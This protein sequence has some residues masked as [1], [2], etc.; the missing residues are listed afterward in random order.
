MT[1]FVETPISDVV[2]GEN[3]EVLDAILQKSAVVKN[4]LYKGGFLAGGF[5]RAILRG[6]SLCQ[7][8]SPS[9]HRNGRN[10]SQGDIDVFFTSSEGAVATV[11]P[12]KAYPSQGGFAHE[13]QDFVEIVDGVEQRVNI[14]FKVQLVDKPSLINRTPAECLSRFDMVNCQVALV[15]DVLIH[16]RD[17]HELDAS[18]KIRIN[19]VESP[20]LGSRILKYVKY[21]GYSGIEESS[22]PRLVEWLAKVASG[23]FPGFTTQHMVGT[24]FAVKTLR[25]GGHI[26]KSELLMFLGKWTELIGSRKD[27]YQMGK[28][29]LNQEQTQVDWA[30]HE[31]GGAA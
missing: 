28:R 5:P 15:G 29:P 31:I 18:R 7:Y 22:Y 19:Q 2:Q 23:G 21:R 4:A 27:N 26:E 25:K 13:K 17:W 30:L 6:D 20:F 14:S 8:F 24:Q 12:F 3:A 9:D 10:H 16:P 11:I 1:Q